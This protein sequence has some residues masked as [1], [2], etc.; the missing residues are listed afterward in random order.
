MVSVGVPQVS[1]D[2]KPEAGATD[3]NRH[4]SRSQNMSEG[5]WLLR[6]TC[7]C[8]NHKFMTSRSPQPR[9]VRA[10]IFSPLISILYPIPHYTINISLIKFAQLSS[11]ELDWCSQKIRNSG[12]ELCNRLR[13]ILVSKLWS[14]SAGTLRQF[15]H[16]FKVRFRDWPRWKCVNCIKLS[17]DIAALKGFSSGA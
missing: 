6:P 14:L 17:V 2:L 9:V 13:I 16:S 7:Q 11:K 10:R 8:Q 5:S 3:T 12:A 1:Q 4:R 15:G